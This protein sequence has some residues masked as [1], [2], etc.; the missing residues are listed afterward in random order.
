M[1]KQSWP[2]PALII[3]TVL[4]VAAPAGAAVLPP[5]PTSPPAY[6]EPAAPEQAPSPG[7]TV[8]DRLPVPGQSEPSTDTAEPSPNTPLPE[9]SAT[10]T[11]EPTPTAD[12]EEKKDLESLIGILG[13]KM[14]QGLERIEDTRDPQVPGAEEIAERIDAEQVLIDDDLADPSLATS[15]DSASGAASPS[16]AGSKAAPASF[17]RV[18]GQGPAISLAADW[19]GGIQ[20]MDVS[21]HQP[22]VNWGNAWNQGARYAYVKAT[23]ATSYTNPLFSRQTSGAAGAGMLHGAYHFAIPS[24]SSGAT[25]ANYFIDN[26]GRWTA[27]GNTLPP[28]LDI[29]YNPYPQLGNTCYNMSADQM[30]AWVRDFSAT[31]AARTGRV[32]MIY[33]TTDWWRTC[34]GNSSAFANHPLHIASYADSVGTLPNGWGNYTLWQYSSTGP[35]EGDSNV[36][37][38]TLTQ[39]RDFARGSRISGPAK[40]YYRGNPVASLDYGHTTDEFVT[41]DWDGDGISSPAAFRDGVWYIRNGLTGNSPVT[42][43]KYG[44]PG[45]RPICGDWNGDGFDTLGVFRNGMAYLRNSNTTGRADGS[46]AFGAAYDV[47]LVGDWNRDGF[48]TLGVARMEGSDKRFYLTDSNIRPGVSQSFIYGSA[49]DT[50]VAGD[51]NNDGFSTVGVQRGNIWYLADNHANLGANTAFMFGDPDDRPLTGRW[52]PG[53]G[54]SV[55]VTR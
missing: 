9:P 38:G 23:E 52:S 17:T 1:I 26:G 35:F 36:Y 8:A 12:P 6:S 30:I 16:P 42:E 34:T 3:A 14:G 24:E 48:D 2:L 45:D 43:L 29:E 21:S 4:A 25:Q 22:S 33:T 47:P 51:W 27:D 40:I 39:L 54:T 49:M 20:G 46:F 19:T 13:A 55:G 50:P 11:P 28:L 10:A 32:P 7:P 53:T 5:E 18:S 41:C 31:V 37:K 15:P 44:E